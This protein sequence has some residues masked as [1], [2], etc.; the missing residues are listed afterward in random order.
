M[1]KH[2]WIYKVFFITFILSLIFS[3]ITTYLSNNFN[4][5]ILISGII[6]I[7]IFIGVIFDMIG[8]SA[9]TSKESS[10]H[11]MNS[12]KIKGAKEALYI[13]NN[14]VTVSSICNDIVGDVCGI[15]SGGLGAVLAISISTKT[16]LNVVLITI[17]ISALISS[18]TVGTKAI[19]KKIALKNSDKI[20]FRTAKIIGLFRK[21][22]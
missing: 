10:F 3:T 21:V 12:K 7:V 22:K 13:I 5:I 4:N 8:T 16:S 19:F 18:L 17:L 9:L 2:N 15:V 14:N 1:K 11:A 6:L 20:V